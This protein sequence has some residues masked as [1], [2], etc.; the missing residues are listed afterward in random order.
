MGLTVTTDKKPVMVFR[1]DKEFNGSTF[2]TYSIGVSSKNKDGKYVNGYISVVFKKG[3]GVENQ[4]KI[5][6]KDSFPI[7]SEGKD[8]NFVKLMIMDFEIVESGDGF[9]DIPEGTQEELPF[10]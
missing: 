5:Y 2:P 6:I 8:R 4:T 7:V 9:M 1:Q 10:K 3:I